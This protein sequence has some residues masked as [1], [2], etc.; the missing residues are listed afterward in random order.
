MRT[1]GGFMTSVIFCL[2]RVARLILFFVA[3]ESSSSSRSSSSQPLPTEDAKSLMPDLALSGRTDMT[4]FTS[5]FV[6]TQGSSPTVFSL[7]PTLAVFCP[8]SHVFTRDVSGRCVSVLLSCSPVCSSHVLW[9]STHTS[10]IAKPDATDL[11]TSGESMTPVNW[12]FASEYVC[13]KTASHGRMT[14]RGWWFH[15]QQGMCCFDSG[16]S[17]V[18][19][20]MSSMRLA[21]TVWQD[22]SCSSRPLT[23]TWQ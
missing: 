11:R 5:A 15:R 4:G 22:V 14:L 9:S 21:S 17:N 3:G 10:D 16:I 13:R 6:F 2:S 7:S 18:S 23:D 20:M 12:F 19:S 8:A 1:P